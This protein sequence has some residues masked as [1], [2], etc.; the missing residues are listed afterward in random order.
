MKN[1]GHLELIMYYREKNATDQLSYYVKGFSEIW[2]LYQ[3]R[4]SAV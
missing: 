4:L 3:H 1:K 2:L